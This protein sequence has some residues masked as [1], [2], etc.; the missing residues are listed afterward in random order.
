MVSRK[1][2]YKKTEQV[3]IPGTL[4]II[5]KSSDTSLQTAVKSLHMQWFEIT[6]KGHY[7]A[8][9]LRKKVASL[10]TFHMKMLALSVTSDFSTWRFVKNFCS[11]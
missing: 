5:I 3:F 6:G 4:L 2:T 1:E 11:K 8:H 9:F 10:K 7:M